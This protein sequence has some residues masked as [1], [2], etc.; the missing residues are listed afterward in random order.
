M[1]KKDSENRRRSSRRAFTLVEVIV[2]GVITALVIGSVSLSL[3]QLGRARNV[4]K[5]RFDAYLRADAALANLRRDIA[6]VIR[7]D[8]LFFT[9]FLLYDDSI[10]S[11]HGEM[12]RD[13][14]LV[15]VTRLRPLRTLEAFSGEGVEYETQYRV[16]E[17]ELGPVL[18]QRRYPIPD[19]YPAGG[20]LATPLVEG[21]VGLTIQA[22]DG[23]SWFDE[24]DSDE[25]GLPLAVSVIVTASGHRGP[26]DVYEREPVVLRTIIPIDRVI[27]PRDHAEAEEMAARE[28]E[29]ELAGEDA[30]DDAGGDTG[31]PGADGGD[32]GGPPDLDDL[33]IPGGDGG[34]GGGGGG[35][36][37]GG[38]GGPGGGGERG[39]SGRTGSGGPGTRNDR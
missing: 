8:D 34:G 24:W 10:P 28:L 4:S 23:E 32:D 18:W 26:E 30:P 3:S 5:V 39:S 31:D 37:R 1:T 12:D 2:A 29:A 6:S 9:R 19:E 21:V 33:D 15:F 25:Q 22:Y 35:G 27:E 20:G 11:P 17:D 7:T 36:G 14:L 38:G 16:E 13:E